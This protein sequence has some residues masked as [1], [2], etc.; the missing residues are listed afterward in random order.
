MRLEKGF[1]RGFKIGASVGETI[2]LS[3]ISLFVQNSQNTVAIYFKAIY[4]FSSGFELFYF[5]IF[6]SPKYFI[7]TFNFNPFIFFIRKSVSIYFS[8]FA[9][10]SL[11]YQTF[12]NSSFLYRI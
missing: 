2:A 11:I 12:S 1:L 10:Q 8:N 3:M 5:S 7:F 4:G 6:F 9:I